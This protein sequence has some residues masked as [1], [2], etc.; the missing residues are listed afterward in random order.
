MVF[1]DTLQ[2]YTLALNMG[3][4][5]PSPIPTDNYTGSKV[6]GTL[7]GLP[8]GKNF[9]GD[10][11]ITSDLSAADLQYCQQNSSSF[12]ADPPNSGCGN[13]N[14]A[15][16]WSGDPLS[17][18]TVYMGLDPK[19][20]PR[21]FINAG[22][23]PAIGPDPEQP[24]WPKGAVVTA[25]SSD[26]K[27]LHVN[28]TKASVLDPKVQL[29]Y[30]LTLKNADGS[31]LPIPLCDASYPGGFTLQTQCDASIPA[32]ASYPLHMEVIAL[33][34]IKPDQPPVISQILKGDYTY[35]K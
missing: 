19:D 13:V 34:F 28:W 21:V 2:I 5:Q 26:G 12:F 35:Q 29:R 11:L 14:L 8:I 9:S 27:T 15:A 33:N 3:P 31:I 24:F 10:P 25:N 4:V 18:D 16:T 32:T 7:W 6:N 22:T 17:R 1:Q 20:M 30:G 23:P